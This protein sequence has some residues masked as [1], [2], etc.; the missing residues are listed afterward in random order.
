MTKTYLFA[1]GSMKKGFNNHYRLEKDILIGEAITTHKYNIYPAPSFKYP[2][3]IEKEKVWQIKGELYEL[4]FTD[5][6]VIDDF[7]GVPHYY[8]RKKIPVIVKDKKYRAF[9]YFKSD[10]SLSGYESDLSMNEWN[11][12]WEKVGDK[13][14][15]YLDEYAKALVE[16]F[17]KW[18]KIIEQT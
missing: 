9:I 17:E 14:S 15:A 4:N 7:E 10:T 1:Y 5:I 8:Y 2:Y 3:G 12:Q 13:L 11:K 16:H 18:E 6:K